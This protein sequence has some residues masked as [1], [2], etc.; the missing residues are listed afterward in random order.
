[1][2]WEILVI[3]LLCHQ[4]VLSVDLNCSTTEFECKF[5]GHCVDISFICDGYKDCHAGEDE[6]DCTKDCTGSQMRCYDGLQCID[7]IFWCDSFEDCA[8]G[9]DEK[10]CEN[11]SVKEHQCP[12]DHFKCGDGWCIPEEML[13]D[14]HLDCGDG[15]DETEDK[16]TDNLTNVQ[17]DDRDCPAPN[18]MC[19]DHSYCIP[20]RFFCDGSAD[21]DDGSDESN[22]GNNTYIHH[23]LQS[24]GKYACMRNHDHEVEVHC[25]TVDHLC[26]GVPQC[27]HGEDEGDFCKASN[28]ST[29]GCDHI[30]MET[31]EGSACY[32]K[33][34]YELSDDGISCQD[35]DECQQY[36]VCDHVCTN[37]QGGYRC[38]CLPDYILHGTSR[39]HYTGGHA[40]IFMAMHN[41]EG[42]E[43]RS[44]DP[45]SK[46]FNQV[47]SNLTMPM[48]IGY[49]AFTH[50]LVWT[51]KRYDHPVMENSSIGS[52]LA[53]KILL[54]TGLE[55][56]ED[57]VVDRISNIVYFSDSAKGT[58]AA[59]NLFSLN[60]TIIMED[61]LQPLGLALH[62]RN[63]L[64]F[65]T[66]DGDLPQITK[67]SQDG[68]GA[69]PVVYEDLLW[70]S[71]IAVDETIDRIFWTDAGKDMIESANLDGSDR[72]E[73]VSEGYHPF[74]IVV[75]EERI[76]WTDHDYFALRSA[77][78][79]TGYDI[80]SEQWS[81]AGKINFLSLNLGGF[82]V[83]SDPCA[84]N[85]CSHLCIPVD[86]VKYTCKCPQGMY[87]GHDSSQCISLPSLE[88]SRLL[89]SSGNS[90]YSITPQHLGVVDLEVVGYETDVV[91]STAPITVADT[92][93]ASTKTGNLVAVNLYLKTSYIISEG[94]D[95]TSLAYDHHAKNLFFIDEATNGIMVMSEITQHKKTLINCTTARALFY[96]HSKHVLTYIDGY[97]MLESSLDGHQVKLLVSHLP[98]KVTALTYNQHDKSYYF[99]DRYFIY[100]H[101]METGGYDDIVRTG[102]DVLS[103]VVQGDALYWTQK[104]SDN[105]FW[106][107]ISR[108]NEDL[109]G[110]VFSLKLNNIGDYP[111][112]LSA[113]QKQI[114]YS[115]GACSSK[116]CSDICIVNEENIGHCI[117]GNGR[118]IVEDQLWNTCQSIDEVMAV[119]SN[120]P[121]NSEHIGLIVATLAC[122]ALFLIL[123]LM[124]GYTKKKSPKTFEF[125]NRSF[126][127]S[128]RN[129]GRDRVQ[130]MSPVVSNKHGEL[131]E[132]YNPSYYSVSLVDCPPIATS[133]IPVS[134]PAFSTSFEKEQEKSGFLPR[135]VRSITKFR[136]P[137]MT[138]VDIDDNNMSFS[139]ESLVG[140]KE[141]SSPI[142]DKRKIPDEVDSAC[143]LH[144]G[145]Q[146]SMEDDVSLNSDTVQ[147]VTKY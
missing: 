141:S 26:D 54:E 66:Q 115:M 140:A 88:Q 14:G 10:H 110:I 9:S 142:S 33:S 100:K 92:L 60:C 85:D 91:S 127:F 3:F 144:S 121:A 30:C 109:N 87:I 73:V 18:Y 130:E 71:G 62:S 48:G 29:K 131:N 134:A 25:L 125:I 86:A 97:S 99:G 44:F 38:E 139:Y 61:L 94:N 89:V 37:T 32:C 24:E 49:D 84:S 136:D 42:G 34:G 72:R 129:S 4:S 20:Q 82:I 22:C 1:M 51:D 103:M 133:H 98:L 16:C 7:S 56:P 128:P 8:D 28:C 17:E 117:C 138:T 123:V 39:C 35:T 132:M 105:I 108:R 135:I 43:I 93:I 114:D 36:G 106:T 102:D 27:P 80:R 143:S 64:L 53:P 137:K 55:E 59:C 90:I 101:N 52:N 57:L 107:D 96:V 78:K 15:E 104:N 58:V 6:M 47:V 63:K 79:F 31:P 77:N 113:S 76:Y 116:Y 83:D 65:V 122:M 11:K 126:G 119:K 69:I 23:C 12:E 147:L 81:Y 111:L 21:C 145:G 68:S 75:F 46:S 120:S 19:P 67:M 124:F 118:S 74:G 112:Y 13:C 5:S 50:S 95:I 45:I 40:E 41:I 2:M 70:P 146:T